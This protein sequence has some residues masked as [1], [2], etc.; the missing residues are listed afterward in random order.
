M[1][2]KGYLATDV[3][4]FNYRDPAPRATKINILTKGNICITS[5]WQ[6]GLGHKGWA[7]L[8]G[9]DHVEEALLGI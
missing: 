5:D 3:I 7:P 8:P 9:R 6:D 4:Q 1:N 2:M